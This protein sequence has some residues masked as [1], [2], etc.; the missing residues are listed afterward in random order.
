MRLPKVTAS[1]AIALLAGDRVAQAI[2]LDLGSIGT[3][4]LRLL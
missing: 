4:S 1:V 3:S 2:N